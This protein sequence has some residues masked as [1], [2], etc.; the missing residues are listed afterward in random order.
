[1]NKSI[2]NKFMF[3]DCFWKVRKPSIVLNKYKHKQNTT[4]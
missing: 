1:M 3:A 4:Q 2:K